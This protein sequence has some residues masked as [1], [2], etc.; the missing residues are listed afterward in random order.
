MGPMLSSAVAG[1]IPNTA[2]YQ[3]GL[4]AG[5]VLN[6]ATSDN[7]IPPMQILS[8]IWTPPSPPAPPFPWVWSDMY[9]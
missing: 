9:I 7:K 6:N 3:L 1:E 4:V 2:Y 8:R 5:R